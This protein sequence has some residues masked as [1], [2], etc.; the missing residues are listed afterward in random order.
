MLEFCTTM[1]IVPVY[2]SHGRARYYF[3]SYGE[4]EGGYANYMLSAQQ[5][6]TQLVREFLLNMH[7][8]QSNMV[9]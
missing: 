5:D 7:E 8:G 6:C 3:R 4:R 9:D 1:L 2:K